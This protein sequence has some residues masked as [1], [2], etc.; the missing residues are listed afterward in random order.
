M[1]HRGAGGP[2]QGQGPPG[3]CSNSKYGFT[4]FE[5]DLSGAVRLYVFFVHAN[6][7]ALLGSPK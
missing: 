6:C 5:A 7:V 4:T 1:I 2:H 3:V